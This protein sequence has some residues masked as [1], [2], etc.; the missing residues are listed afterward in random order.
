MYN[1][2]LILLKLTEYVQ[3]AFSCLHLKYLNNWSML[4]SAYLNGDILPVYI[5]HTDAI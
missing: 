4:K 5:F 2:G 3:R 1:F